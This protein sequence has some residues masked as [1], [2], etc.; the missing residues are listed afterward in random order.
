VNTKTPPRF[1]VDPR[2]LSE[3]RE[4]LLIRIKQF[5]MAFDGLPGSGYSDADGAVYQLIEP[6]AERIGYSRYV[7]DNAKNVEPQIKKNNSRAYKRKGV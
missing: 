3:N 5:F 2:V 6:G 1:K 4:H 7:V